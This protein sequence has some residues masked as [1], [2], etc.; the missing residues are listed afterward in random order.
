MSQTIVQGRHIFHQMGTKTQTV[1]IC[2]DVNQKGVYAE[3]FSL[4]A[5]EDISDDDLAAQPDLATLRDW[6]VRHGGQ[7][8]ATDGRPGAHLPPLLE[9]PAAHDPWVLEA[10]AA[11]D[12]VLVAVVDSFLRDP[13]RHRV[14]HSL[15]AELWS[16]LSQ[17]AVLAGDHL[18][19]DGSTRTQLV[20]KEWPETIPRNKP[21]GTP[22]PRGLFDLAILSPDQVHAA[23]VTQLIFGRIAAPIVIEVGL[24]YGFPHLGQDARKLR[25]SLVPAPY[26]LHLTR[27]RDKDDTRTEQLLCDSS[28][29]V[30]TAYVHLDP[31]GQGSRWKHPGDVTI[32]GSAGSRS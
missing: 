22:R 18:L 9:A 21:D 29:D 27:V 4:A 5:S 13:Y 19:K 23:D 26:L 11:V 32:T 24:D 12:R 3:R 6:L 7:P 8:L 1:S 16:L 25:N 28:H 2:T 17:E 31:A 20:H 30:R 14:E 15:H 10:T